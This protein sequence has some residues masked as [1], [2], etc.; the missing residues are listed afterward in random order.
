MRLLSEV[1][2]SHEK[3]DIL[4]LKIQLPAP[5]SF[6]QSLQIADKV[7]QKGTKQKEIVEVPAIHLALVFSLS[8]D[9]KP[10]TW[11]DRTS[12]PAGVLLLGKSL[13]QVQQGTMAKACHIINKTRVFASHVAR[14]E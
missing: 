3:H 13:E 2:W 4:A 11:N 8:A 10:L 6:V 1:F 12:L 5:Y 14:C 7:L 9:G